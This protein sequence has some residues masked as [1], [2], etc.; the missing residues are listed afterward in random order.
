[1]VLGAVGKKFVDIK[2]VEDVGEVVILFGKGGRD[3]RFRGNSSGRIDSGG[4]SGGGKRVEE[5]KGKG[6]K[7]RRPCRVLFGI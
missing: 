4:G 1:M 6:C 5:A 2:F 7:V 3:R